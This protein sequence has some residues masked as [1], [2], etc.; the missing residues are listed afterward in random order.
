MFA[1]AVPSEIT[2][3]QDLSAAHRQFASLKEAADWLAG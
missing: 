2:L 3:I 1:I